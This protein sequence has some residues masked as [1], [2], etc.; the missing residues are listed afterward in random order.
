MTRRLLF[1]FGLMTAVLCGTGI[2]A[3][4]GRVQSVPA[5][6]I[7]YEQ[8]VRPILSEN[9][10][11]CHSQD[12]RKGGL[13]L[14]SYADVLDGGKDGPI[15]RPGNG[16]GSLL[17]H[18]LTGVVEPQMPK[19]GVALTDE[20]V[21]VIRLW[22]DQGARPTPTSA[23]APA[24]WEATLA[25]LRP[26]VP[27]AAWPAWSA[28]ID[29]FVSQY[30]VGHR[31]AEPQLV[32]DA[33]FARRAY[34]DLWGLLPTPDD[35][36]AF[37]ADRSSN[38]R[39]SLVKRLLD[40]DARYADHWISFWNDLLRN[41][42]GVTYYSEN[43]GR[44]SITS[45]LLA[46]LQSNLRYDQ[47]VSALLNPQSP[48]G[49]EGFLIGVN[50]RGETSAAV[51][52]WMQASQNT[53]QVFLGINLKCNSCHD[54]FVSRWKLK[55]AYGL[56]SY[57]APEGKLQLFRCEVAQDQFVQPAFLYPELD[58]A[59]RSE[60]LADR[61]ATI[62]EIF[63][64]PR[65]GR[66]ARTVVN[67]IW[68]RLLGN[69]IVANSDEMD[70]RPWSPELLDWLSSDFVEHGYDLKRL[71]GTIVA[72]RAYQMPSRPRT[73][74]PP[75]REYVFEGPE[76]RRMTAEQFSDAIGSITGEWSVSTL[77]RV[78]PA[79]P[80]GTQGSGL[81][82]TPSDAASVGAYV[83]EWRMAS[84]SL[85]RALGRPIRDQVTSVRATQPTT[86]QALELVNG[87]ILTRRLLQGARRM[88]GAIG[89]D[90][91]SLYNKAVAGRQARPAIFDI[92]VSTSSKL[93][94]I[95]QEN[96]SNVPQDVLP[97]WAQAEFV[98]ADGV[99]TPLSA[100]APVDSAGLR[101]GSGLV[102]VNGTPG[103]ALRVKNPSTLVYDIG[104]KGFTRFRGAMWLENPAREIGATLDPQIRFYVFD[105]EPD[106]SRLVPP[107]P[108]APLLPGP[109]L[110]T[111]SEVVTRV[112]RYALGRLPTAVERELAEDAIRDGAETVSIEGLADL[113]WAVVMKP[114]FQL[115]Y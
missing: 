68:Q 51:T 6:P 41:D 20:E 70:G 83:R 48:G 5:A 63:T 110:K 53:A 57:F 27:P 31:A 89:P 18:R 58:R 90:R 96:G 9:C 108:G 88:L 22:I 69:G 28:P 66:L 10:L 3:R 85:T 97:V 40:D 11:D 94:L 34:L 23:P 105:V 17:I 15:V 19:D 84:T 99:V 74:D 60:S 76:V 87:E 44:Q 59:P 26:A 62:A 4:S 71:I 102:T 77:G 21:A 78:A 106:F 103:V 55:D 92:S 80:A 100:L 47:F 2:L 24:P 42:D 111:P 8:Q 114:E 45:W 37:V 93:W 7:S 101:S 109:A 91:T 54:S 95:V 52:P 38:K 61:R 113:L 35:L 115:I 13:S 32:S 107:A 82:T 64:D 98:G 75:A 46:S 65:D 112:F 50:W 43:N 79:A 1:T 67:R 81:Q 36:G 49:P 25:L 12:K 16:A 104:G 14:A 39:A 86:P 56:A 72:S 73:A 29:R 33:L 30:L